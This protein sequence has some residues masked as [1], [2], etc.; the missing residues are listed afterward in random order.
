[1][2]FFTYQWLEDDSY[3]VMTY[4]GN[5]E[6]VTIPGTY[7]GKPVTVLYDELFKNHKEIKK[8][9]IPNIVT[10]IGGFVFEGC[11]QLKSVRLPESLEEMWQYAF[12]RSSIEIIEIPGSVRSIIPFTF[13]DCKQLTTVIIHKGVKKIHATAFEGCENLELV[14][15]PSDIEISHNAFADCPKINP[16]IRR[17][18]QSSCRCPQCVSQLK[19][20]TPGSDRVNQFLKSKLGDKTI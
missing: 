5:D 12:V 2:A 16:D 4:E 3:A 18:M 9:H 15:I 14:A 6:E 11:D 19:L 1:M 20:P 13:K 7:S 10:N 8:V 17:E